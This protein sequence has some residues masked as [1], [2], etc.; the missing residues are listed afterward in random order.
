MFGQHVEMRRNVFPSMLN[1]FHRLSMHLIDIPHSAPTPNAIQ[2][3]STYVINLH[4]Q[5]VCGCAC[6]CGNIW[7]CVEHASKCVERVEM[8]RTVSR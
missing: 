5:C 2:Y 7:T 6:V 4:M 8:N 3:L 1:T